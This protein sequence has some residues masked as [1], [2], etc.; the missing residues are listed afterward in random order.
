MGTTADVAFSQDAASP[1]R[2]TPIV[3][4]SPRT[5]EIAMRYAKSNISNYLQVERP[6]EL[7]MR[8]NRG[9]TPGTSVRE[10]GFSAKA[11]QFQKRKKRLGREKHRSKDT[12]HERRP[13]VTEPPF[14]EMDFDTGLNSPF[15]S[16]IP[17]EAIAS[18]SDG[19]VRSIPA[20]PTFR[21]LAKDTHYCPPERFLDVVKGNETD[22]EPLT[23]REVKW[24]QLLTEAVRRA[25]AFPRDS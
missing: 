19:R 14:Y 13:R 18:T 21:G 12:V 2:P 24:N 8:A 10:D 20:T 25:R 22:D 4:L 5:A 15:P 6:F 17:E 11:R 9:S 3:S 7:S 16:F 1:R 23:E